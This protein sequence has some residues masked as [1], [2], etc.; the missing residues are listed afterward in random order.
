MLGKG[1]REE[2][3]R[4]NALNRYRLQEAIND[5]I[6]E[7]I[8]ELA[9]A[10][11]G[12]TVAGISVVKRKTQNF[13]AVLG[14]D[15]SP[16]DRHNSFCL[17]TIGSKE[18]LLV[19]NAAEDMRF[20]ALT[21]VYGPEHIR[22]YLGVPIIS[23]DGYNLAT[24]CV[25]SRDKFAFDDEH[26]EILT[27]LGKIAQAHMLTRSPDGLDMLTGGLIRRRFQ[28]E[29]EREFVRAKRYDRPG[30][31]VFVDLDGFEPLYKT[32]GPD[33]CDE[34]LKVVA[35][36]FMEI[37]RMNDVF[38]RLGGEAFAL[39]LPETLA[40]EAMQC[41][42][43]LRATIAGLRFKTGN[44][45]KRVTAS[46]AV[47]PIYPSVR[48]AIDWF[49][50]ADVTL[51]QAKKNGGNQVQLADETDLDTMLM[52]QSAFGGNQMDLH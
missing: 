33:L 7:N 30:C 31:L 5:I 43:R 8:L 37:T 27:K 38:G 23:P 49:S 32:L 19:H 22:S 12:A 15:K 26:I 48:T 28:L 3:G 46:F 13:I 2:E 10:T 41:A 42:E 18:P 34:A 52:T 35:N 20:S 51:Y 45:V 29:V 17:E 16:I 4:L 36:R 6:F 39:L 21:W 40:H 1:T 47:V 50:R 25:L 9:R 11:T 44:S 24:L 14:A